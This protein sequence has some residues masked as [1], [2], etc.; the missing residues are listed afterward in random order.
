MQSKEELLQ[1]AAALAEQD[2]RRA[3]CPVAFHKPHP[4]QQQFE[5]SLEPIVIAMCGN[6]WGKT[7]ENVLEAI[8]AGLGYRPWKVPGFQLVQDEEGK[9]HFPPREDM[10]P[11]SWV[12]RTD[13]LP[14]SIPSKVAIVSGLPLERG[15]GEIIQAKWYELWP[16][17]VEY[18]VFYGTLGVWRKLRFQNGSEV[19]FGSAS[20]QQLAFEG[21]AADRVVV[22]EPIPKRVYVALRRGLVDKRGQMKWSMTP[23]GDANIAW[24]AA[25]LIDTER[26]DVCIIKGAGRDNPYLDTEALNRFLDDPAMSA[27]E[28]RAR[29]T[30]EIAALGRRIVTPFGPHNSIPPTQIPDT[31]PR[32][33]VVDPHH[34]KPAACI[35]AAVEGE[36]QDTEL[37]VYRESPTDDFHKMGATKMALHDLAGHIKTLEGREKVQWR[38]CDPAF[39][40]QHAKV[41]G[42]QYPSFV[43]QMASYGLVFDDCVD[44]DIDRGI[45]RL[46]DA[47]RL[48]EGRPVPRLRIMSHCKNCLRALSFWS[49][50]ERADETL[51]VSERFKDF[52]DCLRYLVSYEFPI[53]LTKG[54]SYLDE[55]NDDEPLNGLQRR[56]PWRQT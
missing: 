35:W 15:I 5:D 33:L 19:Y 23:L 11:E 8:A 6:R 21:F 16:P 54:L 10:P 17:Q 56:I 51:K 25:D 31:V 45:Q 2:R 34:S 24:V 38:L 22:D 53:L 42:I 27:E 43:E 49:Y 4:G 37:I 30:G 12:L 13:G 52:A 50:E 32:I 14:I 46:R 40:R 9:W 1:L 39:G 28:R 18:K 47:C 7:H 29:E 36:G 55:D 48:I 41:H 26:D 20:Q 44:N 3:E